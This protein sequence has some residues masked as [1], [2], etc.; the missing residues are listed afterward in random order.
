M[1]DLLRKVVEDHRRDGLL[2]PN[3][4][5]GLIQMDQAASD[6][7]GTERNFG[8]QTVLSAYILGLSIP[9]AMFSV[10]SLRNQIIGG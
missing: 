6:E 7:R 8:P 9:K 5:G 10:S 4:T 2:V 1:D 3:R